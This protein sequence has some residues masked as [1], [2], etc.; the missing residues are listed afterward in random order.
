M[1]IATKLNL[2]VYQ[3]DVC[4]AFL[5]STIDEEIYLKLPENI[6]IEN[7]KNVICKLNKSIY[8]LKQSPK[9]WNQTFDKV[10]SSE[11]FKRSS[12]DSCLYIKCNDNIK[13]F[14]LLYVD[15]ILLFGNN[16]TELDR[17]K[18]VLSKSFEMKDM[19]KIV[20][21]LDISV[22]QDLEKGTTKINQS[23]YLEGVLKKIWHVKL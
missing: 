14:L 23:E 2:Q 13:V 15:D 6:E 21:Y 10:M 20:K 16:G 5:N 22:Q 18:Q 12:K 19:G 1:S 11:G 9:Y 3:M 17:L 8:G 4:S 7:N